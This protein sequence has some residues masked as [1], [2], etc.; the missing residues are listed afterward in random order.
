MEIRKT[1]T[2]SDAEKDSI[3]D[4]IR[5]LNEILNSMRDDESLDTDYN[6]FEY[7]DIKAAV[8]LLEEFTDKRTT[9]ISII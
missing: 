2:F 9:Y 4:T 1:I 3:N 8:N 7:D 5:Y 6:C